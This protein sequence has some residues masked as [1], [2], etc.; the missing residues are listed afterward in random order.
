MARLLGVESGQDAVIRALLYERALE[1]VHPYGIAV[2]EF[3]NR[4]LVLR[5][6]QG[7]E[8]TKDEGL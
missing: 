3:T 1:M 2:A 8:G 5:N 6:K 4:I 7:H